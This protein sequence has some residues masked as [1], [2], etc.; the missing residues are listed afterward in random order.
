METAFFLFLFCAIYL[1]EVRNFYFRIPYWDTILHFFSGAMLGALGFYLVNL[2][3]D[4]PRL[5]FALSAGF[6]TLFAFC[7]GLAAGA[8]WEIYEY[9]ADTLFGTNMQKYM[10]DTGTVLVGNAA[11]TDTMKDLIVDAIAV[12]LVSTIGFFTIRDQMVVRALEPRA[13]PELADGG[14]HRALDT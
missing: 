7:F 6:V 3:N 14:S 9:T 4:S 1:G 11:L 10:T 5:R 13:A 2:L 8:V 12:A